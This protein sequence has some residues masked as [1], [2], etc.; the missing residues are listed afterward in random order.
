MYQLLNPSREFRDE[1]PYM[2]LGGG[3]GSGGTKKIEYTINSV[4]TAGSGSPHNGKNVASATVVVASCGEEALIGT[5]VSVVDNSGCLFNEDF[6]ALVGR[7]GWAYWAVAKDLSSG[8]GPNDIGP[9]HW[10]ADGLCCP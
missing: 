4:S 2:L 7:H 10:S 8:A 1:P 3:G 9:C 6:S 5:T